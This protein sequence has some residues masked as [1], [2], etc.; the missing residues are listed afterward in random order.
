M[1]GKLDK[2]LDEIISTQRKTSVRG[3][4]GRRNTTRRVG[5]GNTATAAPVGGIKKN[6]R[7]ARGAAKAVPTGPAG[8]P[9]GRILVSG[10]P[11]DITEAMIKEYFAKTI[12]PVK[13][14]ELSYGPG[15]QSRGI[16]TIVF[17]RSDMATKAV[18]TCNNIPVDG[19]P[20]R[21]ELILDANAAKSIP[22]PKGLSERMGQPKSQ[23]KSAANPKKNDTSTRGKA[24]RGRGGKTGRNAR[25][26]K[27]T[28]EELDSEMVDYWNTGTATTETGAATNGAAPAATNGDANM[29]DEIL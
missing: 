27:K 29:D 18:N 4:G 5:A 8:I 20:I 7:Q 9:D 2:S 24:A 28:A 11:K 17:H 22:A 12:G 16:A 23:P 14:V 6:P 15:G 1:S 25:P 21:V 13:R 26:A 3:R 10:F 19:K